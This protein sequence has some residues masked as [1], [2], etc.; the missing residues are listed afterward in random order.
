M[1]KT[2]AMVA[3]VLAAMLA[4][5]DAAGRTQQRH[6]HARGFYSAPVSISSGYSVNSGYN[7]PRIGPGPLWAGPNECWTDEG[8]GR[9]TPCDG[10][11][12]K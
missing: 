6:Q 1:L 5:A 10:R 12:V 2:T 8:Y 9:Y 4:Q 3:V 11:S 7:I